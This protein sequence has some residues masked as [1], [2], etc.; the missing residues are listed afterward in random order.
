MKKNDSHEEENITIKG[1]TLIIKN[2]PMNLSGAQ[3]GVIEFN[4]AT[5]T[6]LFIPSNDEV[7]PTGESSPCSHD[8]SSFSQ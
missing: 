2:S 1:H 8:H 3:M 7:Q 4:E 5:Q 6:Y